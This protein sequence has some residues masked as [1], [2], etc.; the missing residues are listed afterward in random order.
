LQHVLGVGRVACDAI[1]RAEHQAVMSLEHPL[2]IIR[3]RSNGFLPN[4]EL[5]RAP[6]VRSYLRTGVWVYY[7]RRR[8]RPA[9]RAE[10]AEGRKQEAGGRRQVA[11]QKVGS[12]VIVKSRYKGRGRS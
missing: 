9:L 10:K 2:E 12:Q 3:Y 6:P 1:R 4:R 7:Y 5:Q 11:G 8:S